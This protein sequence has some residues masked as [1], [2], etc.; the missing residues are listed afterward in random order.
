MAWR[1]SES[2][3]PTRR[4]RISWGQSAGTCPDARPRDLEHGAHADPH[5]PAVEGR[6]RWGDRHPSMWRSCRRAEDGPHVGGGPRCPQAR[7]PPGAGAQFLH[8]GQGRGGAWRTVPRRS[9]RSPSRRPGCPG[10]QCR[11]ARPRSGRGM[12][13]AGPSSWRR[14]ISRETGSYPASRAWPMTLGLSAMNRALSGARRLRSWAS[15]RRANTSS[16]GAERSV[17]SMMW[18]HGVHLAYSCLPSLYRRP[19]GRATENSRAA[20]QHGE[21]ARG[22]GAS[23]QSTGR[24]ET[25]CRR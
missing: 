11:G 23:R 5:R 16:S 9:A 13:R 12:S 6:S 19:G 7:P 24:P 18:G 25:E 2:P 21:A 17:I 20:S 3:G 8:G 15:V 14:S 22:S 4:S 1:R 10:Q